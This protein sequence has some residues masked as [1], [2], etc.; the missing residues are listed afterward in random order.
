MIARVEAARYRS[1]DEL[2]VEPGSLFVL[3]V[4]KGTG[5]LHVDR[6]PRHI[7]PPTLRQLF[8]QGSLWP[9]DTTRYCAPEELISA[10]V[11]T[12]HAE[13][14]MAVYSMSAS[15]TSAAG[16]VDQASHRVCDFLRAW[17]PAEGA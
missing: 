3:V 14:P 17:F 6:A 8:A 15:K 10:P 12:K 4:A 13:A 1:F 2:G 16:C 9:A 5:H 7:G 11:C